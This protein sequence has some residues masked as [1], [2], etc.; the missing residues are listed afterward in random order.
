HDEDGYNSFTSRR[1]VTRLFEVRLRVSPRLAEEWGTDHAAA[2]GRDPK[3]SLTD[4]KTFLGFSGD[5]RIGGNDQVSWGKI[6]ALGVRYDFERAVPLEANDREIAAVGGEHRADALSLG[7]MG[8]G[9]V[10]ELNPGILVAA[11]DGGDGGQ[12]VAGE[13]QEGEEAGPEPL[14]D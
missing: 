9:R 13:R 2:D 11:H 6:R 12:V 10:G 5:D 4:P 7:E 1:S 3:Q 14:D 8:E